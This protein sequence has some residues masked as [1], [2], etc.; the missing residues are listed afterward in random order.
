MAKGVLCPKCSS[1]ETKVVDSRGTSEH[2]NR[3][4]RLCKCGWRFT[5]YEIIVGEGVETSILELKSQAETVER[6]MSSLLE[7]V[8]K[9]VKTILP[10]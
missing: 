7:L 3:R 10:Q 8:K 5:T 1:D 2:S 9:S 4:R 6:E